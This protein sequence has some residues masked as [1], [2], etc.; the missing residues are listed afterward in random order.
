MQPAELDALRDVSARVGADITLVQ[1]AGGNSSIQVFRGF[2]GG[3]CA[4]A[5]AP[6]FD[7]FGRA[8]VFAMR[9]PGI[10]SRRP[11]SVA[12][13]PC[14]S[15]WPNPFDCSVSTRNHPWAAWRTSNR[16]S[17]VR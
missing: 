14:M 16:S 8:I 11:F 13:G 1:G 12:N 17:A 10:A 5:F 6:V 3:S 15:S 7:R 2:L 4:D 9:D